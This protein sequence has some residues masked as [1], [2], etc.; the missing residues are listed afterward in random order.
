MSE[1]L[2]FPPIVKAALCDSSGLG[3]EWMRGLGASDHNTHNTKSIFY[4][5]VKNTE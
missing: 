2:P 3:A 5:C 1:S 4:V